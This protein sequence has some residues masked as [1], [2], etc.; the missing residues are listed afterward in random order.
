MLCHEHLQW[1]YLD[2]ILVGPYRLGCGA[3]CGGVVIDVLARTLSLDRTTNFFV[4]LLLHDTVRHRALVEE[5]SFRQV[6]EASRRHRAWVINMVEDQ[7]ISFHVA[8]VLDN[9]TD[10]SQAVQQGSDR[11]TA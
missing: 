3:S 5:Q 2:L 11:D 8:K 9:P 1:H 6:E 7:E 10:L 4:L